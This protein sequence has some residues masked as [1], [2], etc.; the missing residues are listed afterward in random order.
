MNKIYKTIWN[1][2]K[3]CLSVVSE[4]AKSHG[5]SGTI[6]KTT[7]KKAFLLMSFTAMLAPQVYATEYVVN[8]GQ[9]SGSIT[10]RYGDTQKVYGTANGTKVNISGDIGAGSLPIQYVY[11][12]GVANNTTVNG[13]GRQNL[14]SGGTANNTTVTGWKNDTTNSGTQN[15]FD[16]GIASNATINEYG[17]QIISNGGSAISTTIN[18]GGNSYIYEGGTANRTTV[19]AGGYQYLSGG[20]ASGTVLSGSGGSTSWLDGVHLTAS[21]EIISGTAYG[22]KINADGHQIVSKDAVA[23][24]TIIRG[25]SGG[26]N[27]YGAGWQNVSGI[28]KGTTIYDGGRQ[29]VNKGG[30]ASSTTISGGEQYVHEGG[31]A[32]YTTI[33]S[34]IQQ[35]SGTDATAFSTTIAGSGILEIAKGGKATNTKIAARGAIEK[36]F[37]KGSATGTTITQGTQEVAGNAFSTS[38]T[39]ADSIQ[40][41]LS[42]GK[43]SGTTL[44][45]GG[46]Q[47]IQ[48]GGSATDTT[49]I[50]AYQDVYGTANS[51]T[52][53]SAADY[54]FKPV[55]T[56][57]SGGV[58]NNTTGSGS[59]AQIVFS[60]GIANS[61]TFTNNHSDN[62]SNKPGEGQKIY[63]GGIANDTTLNAGQQ[64]AGLQ[65]I[66]SGGTANRT[67]INGINGATVGT[68]GRQEIHQYGNANDTIINGGFQGIGVA[69]N[70]NGTDYDGS[71]AVANRTSVGG[72]FYYSDNDSSYKL[73]AGNQTLSAYAGVT[74][75]DTT[76]N[77]GGAQFVEGGTAN[78]TTVNAGGYQ[79]V[80]GG[81]ANHTTL[82][83]SPVEVLDKDGN[84]IVGDVDFHLYDELIESVDGLIVS[85]AQQS[86][87][88]GTAIST[89]V[90]SG[91][92]QHVYG[93]DEDAEWWNG[94]TAL[95]TT[96]NAGGKQYVYGING[97]VNIDEGKHA[98]IAEYT[99]INS[100]G[101]QIVS[102][103]GIANHTI[104]NAYGSQTVLAGGSANYTNVFKD[105]TITVEAGGFVSNAWLEE[106]AINQ[107]NSGAITSNVVLGGEG[108]EQ[109]ISSGGSAIGTKILANTNQIVSSGGEAIDTTVTEGGIQTLETGASA[110]SSTIA[111]GGTLK[112]LGAATADALQS[113]GDIVFDGGITMNEAVP[114][115]TVTGESSIRDSTINVSNIHVSR[116]LDDGTT[117]LLI[118]GNSLDTSN[119]SFTPIAEK[120]VQ[121]DADD[122]IHRYGFKGTIAEG[123]VGLAATRELLAG[124][125][126]EDGISIGDGNISLTE[127]I[128]TKAIAGVYAEGNDVATSGTVTINGGDYTSPI[129]G[130]YSKS[131][132]TSSNAVTFKAGTLTGT[133][134]GG[135]TPTGAVSSNKVTIGG[136]TV[137]NA[138]GGQGTSGAVTGNSVTKT[139]GTVKTALRGGTTTSGKAEKNTVTISGKGSNGTVIGGYSQKGAVTSNKVTVS[140]STTSKDIAGGQGTSGA[141]ASNSVT[142]KGGT[143]ATIRGG[144]GSTGAVSKNTV[145]MSGG[146]ITNIAGGQG[147]S[148]T[149]TGNVVKKTGGTVKTA[150]RGGY[151]TAGGAVTKNTVT[152]SGKGSNGTVVGGYSKS[153]AVKSNKVTISGSTTSKEI[154]GGQSASGAVTG[155]TVTFK[156]GKVTANIYGGLSTKGKVTGNKVVLANATV[157]K[158]VYGGWTKKKAVN[159]S[160]SIAASG[161]NTVGAL[162]GYKTLSLTAAKA[163]KTKAIITVTGKK[164]AS[165]KGKTLSVTGPSSLKG[166]AKINLLKASKGTL[167]LTGATMKRAGTFTNTS[168]KF[169]SSAGKVKS[170]VINGTGSTISVTK[171]IK[172]LKLPASAVSQATVAKTSAV[173]TGA[174]TSTAAVQPNATTSVSSVASTGTA[175]GS[176]VSTPSTSGSTVTTAS[177]TTAPKSA[178]PV[179]GA[180]SGGTASGTLVSSAP[181]STGTSSGASD[182]G[183]TAE[184]TGTLTATVQAA[185]K[186]KAM[187][188][189]AA[190]V[191]LLAAESSTAEAGNTTVSTDPAGTEAQ[192]ND[193]TTSTTEQSPS[194]DAASASGNTNTQ[195]ADSQKSEEKAQ[196]KASDS[197]DKPSEDKKSDSKTQTA[198]ADKKAESDKKRAQAVATTEEEEETEEIVVAGQQTATENS[199]TL[200]EALLGT[201]ALVNQG[202]EFIADQGMAAIDEAAKSGTNVFGAIHG[203][204]SRYETGSHIDL[205]SV[206]LMA[207][208]AAK[209]T[210]NTTLAG[211]IEAGWGNSKSHV[212]GAKGSGEHEYY[213]IGIAGKYN[214]DNPFYVDGSIRLG[215]AKTDF[216]GRYTGDKAHYK[217]ESFYTAAHIGGGYVFNIADKTDLD[218]YGRYAITWLDGDDVRLHDRD[219][220]R[221]HMGSST[222]HA[223]R[224]GFRFT[225]E[226]T[227]TLKWKAGLAYEH[228]FNGDARG[229]INGASLDTPT[230]QGNTGIGEVGLVMKPSA[231]SPWTFDLTAKGYVGDRRGGAGSITAKYEF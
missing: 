176:L 183:T 72:F 200:S 190:P 32:E 138:Y 191:T 26:T 139:G 7:A 67:R 159:T 118:N 20:N 98:G 21:E 116:M 196:T 153:G 114:L 197:K 126:I 201:I 33:R 179:T 210:A 25:L 92:I 152:I 212:S 209:P 137:T 120:V 76:L 14:L 30:V 110:I 49:L 45:Y 140:G 60:G 231:N 222:T 144:Y 157:T 224:T 37:Q 178:T 115:L 195:G 36:I 27:N 202:T 181:A 180:S 207:G 3:R 165:F 125:Y 129:Y 2:A 35:I 73:K 70:Y 4:L 50:S 205:D 6:V 230:L 122:N 220:S 91:G 69:Y 15:I 75:N 88:D 136:G 71:G 103:G 18:S 162:D 170:L 186:L 173:S 11:A 127:S 95:D 41:I 38:V 10:L 204:S 43:A 81:V 218:L 192:G 131:G 213:G 108:A 52:L 160:N 117:I 90:N 141:I 46:V 65:R 171:S 63:A 12:G 172:K 13:Y 86:I 133:I 101:E 93:A 146:T 83:G 216:D 185:P 47:T 174:S 163:N 225:G 124:K 19:N 113:K 23:S 62:G 112:V 223:V 99:T 193:G 68:A 217:N 187:R 96:V 167:N 29:F 143:A 158:G 119:V 132:L 104:V 84:R 206:S 229:N 106:G 168:W 199:K 8:A 149:V 79:S 100:G 130:G 77:V 169:D 123:T 214:F 78:T 198:S 9:T 89:T 57:Y 34:G 24:N 161:V 85:K 189:A 155:N 54:A 128:Q 40:H 135:Y 51:T 145:T 194:N 5:G 55:Q 188:L 151:A 148:K 156:G 107:I 53:I 109:S 82:N 147:K 211:F 42:G 219:N 17:V 228:I 164:G 87:T 66:Y 111:Q 121:M 44:Q 56:V 208:V 80:R 226:A 166:A 105:G 203:G 64:A 134:Y 61:A 1:K 154:R 39:G 48:K 150:L 215:V 31:R 175:S 58:A 182:T 59:I 74:A 227:D 16:G 177:Q 22:T 142:F 28:A 97:A 184:T 221:F 94:G 102:S